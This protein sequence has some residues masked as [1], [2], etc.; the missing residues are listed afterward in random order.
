MPARALA[1]F[2]RT[3]AAVMKTGRTNLLLLVIAGLLAALVV[4]EALR[5]KQA[6]ERDRAHD[7]AAAEQAAHL[8]EQ[9]D[10]LFAETRAQLDPSISTAGAAAQVGA[11]HDT[12]DPWSHFEQMHRE[13]SRMFDQAFADFDHYP[14]SSLDRGWDQI[15]PSPAVDFRSAPE[16]YTIRVSLP[17][18]DASSV[19]VDARGQTL[20]I[21]AETSV[22]HREDGASGPVRMHARRSFQRSVRLP[23][24]A[25]L[26]ETMQ[27]DVKDGVLVIEVAR[28]AD[29]AQHAPTDVL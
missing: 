4:V 17:G 29:T 12:R 16:A 25:V 14:L 5:W 11:T 9:I 24:D 2:M 27:V 26:D 7:A 13:I 22:A 6:R 21:A 23:A 18:L 3:V 1:R 28:R 10:R 20:T 19:R 15:P 8:Q